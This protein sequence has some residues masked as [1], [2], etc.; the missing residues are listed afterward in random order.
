MSE[1]AGSHLHPNPDAIPVTARLDAPVEQ[2]EYLIGGE[3]RRWSG[4]RRAVFSPVCLEGAGG[5]QQAFLGSY[6]SLTAKESL[7]ALDAAER[8]YDHGRGPWP[9]MPVA[10]RIRHVEEFA[11]R[12]E[13]RRDE[14]VRLLMWEIGKTPA[15]LREGVRP[16]RRV[17]PRHHRGAEGARPRLVALRHRARG[18]SARSAARRWGWCSAWGRST[19]R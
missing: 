18:S 12:M 7:Q 9:T 8:A 11:R 6:P 1:P 15:G 10:E 13:A 19:T 14:V 5:I 2:T 3:I 17:H 4:P 16:H